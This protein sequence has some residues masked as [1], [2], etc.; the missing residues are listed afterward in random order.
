MKPSP[1][2]LDIYKTT[3][4]YGPPNE[5]NLDVGDTRNLFISG[6]CALTLDWGDIGTLAID[7]KESKVIDKVGAVI[8]ARLDQGARSRHRQAGRLRCND[9]APTRSTASTTRRSQRSAAGQAASTP[10]PTP[11]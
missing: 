4:Q 9:S 8:S 2:A 6:Q 10:R 3:T 11:R 5:I 1:Q 7:P